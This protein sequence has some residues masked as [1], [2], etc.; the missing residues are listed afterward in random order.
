MSDCDAAI[1]MEDELSIRIAM[2]KYGLLVRLV[3]A[4]P[5]A[6]KVG[7]PNRPANW[8]LYAAV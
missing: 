4:V 2:S 6:G 5:A 1:A 8:V 3:E 7:K